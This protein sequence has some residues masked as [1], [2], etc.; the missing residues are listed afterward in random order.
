MPT[1][2]AECKQPKRPPVAVTYIFR[3]VICYSKNYPENYVFSFQKKKLRQAKL[4][5]LSA[6]SIK[7][8][9]KQSRH[10]IMC[11]SSASMCRASSDPIRCGTIT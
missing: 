6:Y 1:C 11:C 4:I 10:H 5:I 7:L 2:S 3:V 8:H 9:N